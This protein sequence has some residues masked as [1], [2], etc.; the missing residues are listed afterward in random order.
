MT[1]IT[2]VVVVIN[3]VVMTSVVIVAATVLAVR[4]ALMPF[5]Q[6]VPRV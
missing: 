4:M 1:T 3:M 2:A 5:E 6:D